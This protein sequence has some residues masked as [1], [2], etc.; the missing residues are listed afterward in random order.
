MGAFDSI[1]ITAFPTLS[2]SC[3]QV[4]DLNDPT[5]PMLPRAD[6]ISAIGATRMYRKI[7]DLHAGDLYDLALIPRFGHVLIHR[8]T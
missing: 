7:F 3:M 4:S 5:T 2:T 1:S 8:Q 6:F